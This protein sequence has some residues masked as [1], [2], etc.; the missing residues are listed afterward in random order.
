MNKFNYKI[1]LL[2]PYRK[3]NGLRSV[4]KV[5]RPLNEIEAIVLSFIYVSSNDKKQQSKSFYEEFFKTFNLDQEK[6]KIFFKKILE[7]MNGNEIEKIDLDDENLLCGEIKIIDAIF[8]NIKNQ[9]FL[10]IDEKERTNSINLNFSVFRSL[11]PREKNILKYNLYEI[12]NE[13]LENAKTI[14]EKYSKN[15]WEEDE[16]LIDEESEKI[17]GNNE[18]YI[19]KDGYERDNIKIT[20]NKEEHDLT[21]EYENQKINITSDNKL[22]LDILNKYVKENLDELITYSITDDMVDLEKYIQNDEDEVIEVININDYLQIQEKVNLFNK[23]NFVKP[24]DNFLENNGNLFNVNKRRFLIN[25][26][27]NELKEKIE[28][29]ILAKAKLSLYEFFVEQLR[30]KNLKNLNLLNKLNE[31]EKR[32]I[33]DL[34]KQNILEWINLEH[35]KNYII[36]NLID[37]IDSDKIIDFIRIDSISNEDW[38]NILKN[39]SKEKIKQTIEKNKNENLSLKGDQS[40][41]KLL[42][43]IEFYDLDIYNQNVFGLDFFEEIKELLNDYSNIKK[44]S[45]FQEAKTKKKEIELKLQKKWQ[46]LYKKV[47]N[48]NQDIDA[49]IDILKEQ[50]SGKI[51]ELWYDFTKELESIRKENEIKTND[52][53][54]ESLQSTIY[55][56]KSKEIKNKLHEIR[57]KRNRYT[58]LDNELPNEQ[59][60]EKVLEISKFFQESIKFIKD[61]K[62]IINKEIEESIIEENKKMKEKEK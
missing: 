35:I 15:T 34:I 4:Y 1:K 60:L 51:K 30:N 21:F 38:I 40:L 49:H 24:I 56:I 37:E 6:W 19:R 11:V 58:H 23:E 44:I 59:D 62:K 10:G 61:N 55:R 46:W 36:N 32:K 2:I 25:F 17:K 22:T 9:K 7:K 16:E 31:L 27:G 18:V 33:K 39:D 57:K 45:D 20:F 54:F 26:S 13:V 50:S 12:N 28:L 41:K 53:R 3:Y 14:L 8:E 42:T 29:L 43:T 52:G 5:I 47:M 48:N